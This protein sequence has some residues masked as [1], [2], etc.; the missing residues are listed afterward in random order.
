MA[1]V[2]PNWRG[3][4]MREP[5]LSLSAAAVRVARPASAAADYALRPLDQHELAAALG[6]ALAALDHDASGG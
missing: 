5:R 1:P 2:C 6:A 4:A 3:A